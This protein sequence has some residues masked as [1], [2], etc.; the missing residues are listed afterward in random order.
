MRSINAKHVYGPNDR[1]LIL[2]RAC[3]LGVL[4]KN[5]VL[6]IKKCDIVLILVIKVEGNISLFVEYWQGVIDVESFS[7]IFLQNKPLE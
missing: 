3:F 6:Q 5:L 7:Q 4:K 1:H 2:F